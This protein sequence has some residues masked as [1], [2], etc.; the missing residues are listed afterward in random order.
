[1]TSTGNKDTIRIIDKVLCTEW[2]VLPV[3]VRAVN[4]T[5]FGGGRERRDRERERAGVKRE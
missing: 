2:F 3:L 5:E 1:M 4:L